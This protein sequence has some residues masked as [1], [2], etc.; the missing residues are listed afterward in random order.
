MPEP[1]LSDRIKAALLSAHDKMVS[2]EW[3]EGKVDRLDPD[4]KLGKL[5]AKL[6]SVESKGKAVDEVVG[7]RMGK[8]GGIPRMIAQGSGM[9]VDR[10]MVS[11]D[12]NPRDEGEL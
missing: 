4:S 8:M 9:P 11:F 2:G 6:E 1:S 5:I 10:P 3:A 7:R 12:R